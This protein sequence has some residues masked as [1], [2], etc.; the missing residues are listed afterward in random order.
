DARRA[1]AAR[2]AHGAWPGRPR[3]AAA[4]LGALGREAG[5]PRFAWDSYR[6]FVQMYGEVVEGVPAHVY[7]DALTALKKARGAAQ[8]TDLSTDDL[9]ELVD[10][11]KQVSRQHIGDDLPSDPRE[12]LRRAIDAVFRSWLNPRAR[13]YRRA[14]GIPD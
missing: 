8:D 2:G 3:A 6:R 4:G 12:A 5:D 1:R 7:E 13:V 10:T 9:R 14:N 11:F